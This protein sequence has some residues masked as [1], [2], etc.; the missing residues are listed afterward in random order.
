MSYRTLKDNPKITYSVIRKLSGYSG[1]GVYMCC[2][3]LGRKFVRKV[4]S[5]QD[6]NER[7]ECQCE[8]QIAFQSDGSFR[9]PKIYRK[10]FYDGLFYFDMEFVQGNTLAESFAEL[11]LMTVKKVLERL[12]KSNVS[13]KSL[14]SEQQTRLEEK[15]LNLKAVVPLSN[16]DFDI[17]EIVE[18]INKNFLFHSWC[19]GDL[20][21][22]NI[23][24]SPKKGIY[25]FDFLDSFI[26]SWLIDV[27][28][29]LQDLEVGWSYRRVEECRN[30]KLKRKILV[31]QVDDWLIKFDPSKNTIRNV[32]KLLLLNL[33]RIFPYE[34]NEEDVVFLNRAL[35]LVKEKIRRI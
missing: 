4:S 12:L 3:D 16:E 24:I 27:A 30:A 10:G 21:L 33:L 29:L 1:C 18:S 13:N 7:L 2:D 31:E 5:N 9:S 8:K 23:I 20:T 26:D 34:T 6:Y 11:D 22:E 32:Y 28:K 35:C 25:L 14:P 15:I 19:H 17:W